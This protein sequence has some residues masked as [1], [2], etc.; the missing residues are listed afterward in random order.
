MVDSTKRVL[1]FHFTLPNRTFW[2]TPGGGLN[3]GENFEQAARRELWEE[4]GH[5]VQDAGPLGFA[6]TLPGDIFG[7]YNDDER[8]NE[9]QTLCCYAFRRSV[10]QQRRFWCSDY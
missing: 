1:S 10:I 4:T 6:D 3:D 8:A 5:V 2:A 9:I 7:T